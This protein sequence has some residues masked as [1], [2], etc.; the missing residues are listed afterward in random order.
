MYASVSQSRFQKVRKTGVLSLLAALG[1]LKG[2]RGE[3]PILLYHSISNDGS[4][5]SLT[6]AL[7]RA[8]MEYLKERGYRVLSLQELFHYMTAR[9]FPERSAVITFDDGLKNNYTQAFPVLKELE[10]TATIF[11]A[12]HYV[13]GRSDWYR[14]DG[15]SEVPM[16]SWGEIEEMS[17]AGIDFQ[18]HSCYHPPLDRLEEGE[19]EREMSLSRETIE[20]RL[21]RPVEAFCYP[22]G[23]RDERVIGAVKRLGFRAA[24]AGNLGRFRRGD[25]PFEIRRMDM[26]L[27]SIEHPRQARLYL[28]SCLQG[29]FPWYIRTRRL[30]M[31]GPFRANDGQ[32]LV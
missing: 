26:T 5:L 28:R 24:F 12:T 13:G 23:R 19:I 16:L 25:D 18:A 21:G 9:N 7:F 22:F 8:Q 20:R 6:P 29:T 32:Y 30:F 31:G 17:A 4:P 2:G 10:F 14:L 11:L 1:S 27:M 3:I 15:L